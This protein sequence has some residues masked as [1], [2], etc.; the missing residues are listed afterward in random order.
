MSSIST[1]I[2]QFI[3]Q[4]LSLSFYKFLCLLYSFSNNNDEFPNTS[5]FGHVQPSK[6]NKNTQNNSETDTS[7]NNQL[8]NNW[9]IDNFI[10]I[11]ESEE[12]IYE[13]LCYVT[14]SSSAFPLEVAIYY[15]Y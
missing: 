11:D 8:K 14:I 9:T 2:F 3:P 7:N 12:K 10:A 4:P 1:L 15:Y 6:E 13:D 5:V